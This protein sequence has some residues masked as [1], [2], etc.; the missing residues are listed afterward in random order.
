M[1]NI[2]DLGIRRV[3]SQ[4]RKKNVDS[5]S[6]SD[7]N[8][9]NSQ[10]QSENKSETPTV[11]GKYPEDAITVQHFVSPKD[12]TVDLSQERKRLEQQQSPYN[13]LNIN[14]SDS[15]DSRLGKK[16][17][18]KPKKLSRSLKIK[19]LSKSKEKRPSENMILDY[20]E[21]V[22]NET[23]TWKDHQTNT[24]NYSNSGNTSKISKSN[25]AAKDG[26]FIIRI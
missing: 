24:I 17:K 23:G 18:I 5:F 9:C 15:E 8:G 6:T 7:I 19:L 2:N 11:G 20:D 3:L 14:N 25:K 26:L 22:M 13:N 16:A 21:W 10:V 4:V 1:I 12:N